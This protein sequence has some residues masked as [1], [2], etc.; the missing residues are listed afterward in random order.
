MSQQ[1][2]ELNFL[3][4]IRADTTKK[5]YQFYFKKYKEFVNGK[6]LGDSRITI[7]NQIIDFLLSLK[8]KGLSVRIYEI[9]S[10]CYNTFL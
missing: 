1:R 8:A 2:Y 9:I 3:N 5:C 6:V 7:D 4:S 10:I